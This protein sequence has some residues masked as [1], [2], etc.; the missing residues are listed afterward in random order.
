[1]DIVK[2]HLADI[3]QQLRQ[4]G[5]DMDRIMRLMQEHK[6]TQMLRDALARQLGSDIMV[7]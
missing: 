6:D 2:R 4:A 5:S 3:Q 7:N 1:M